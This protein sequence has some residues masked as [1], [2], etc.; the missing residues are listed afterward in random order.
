MSG[1]SPL[2]T[3]VYCQKS[4]IQLPISSKDLRVR[5][6]LFTLWDF[7][8]SH[9]CEKLATLQQPGAKDEDRASNHGDAGEEGNRE[10]TARDQLGADRETEKT[11]LGR[12]IS[13]WG[14]LKPKYGDFWDTYKTA[15][16]PITSPITVP[17][18]SW[19]RDLP[20][21]E[22]TCT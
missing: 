8:H 9:L 12:A 14:F 17:C 18:W 7:G 1:I 22:V 21:R 11:T 6:A 2:Y 15:M 5:L 16:E 4:S 19:I 13:F 3:F 10:V 20:Q